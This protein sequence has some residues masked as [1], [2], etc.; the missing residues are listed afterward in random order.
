MRLQTCFR[1]PKRHNK[2]Y[3]Q[4]E[5]KDGLYI[6]QMVRNYKEFADE[7]IKKIIK[8]AYLN[9]VC[10]ILLQNSTFSKFILLDF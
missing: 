5:S 4:V 6:I 9:T 1:K 10:Q 8:L 7:E 2:N 3:G